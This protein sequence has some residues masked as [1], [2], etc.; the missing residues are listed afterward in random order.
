MF[1]PRDLGHTTARL[2]L[3][4]GTRGCPHETPPGSASAMFGISERTSDSA[5][6]RTELQSAKSRVG[7]QPMVQGQPLVAVRIAQS[8]PPHHVHH[9]EHRHR[10]GVDA[11]HRCEGLDVDHRHYDEADQVEKSEAHDGGIYN[12]VGPMTA[13]TYSTAQ[14]PPSSTPV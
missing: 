6:R 9:H 12:T 1:L 3:R 5:G 14:R 8:A 2:R 4:A 7:G 13:T 11:P 10:G